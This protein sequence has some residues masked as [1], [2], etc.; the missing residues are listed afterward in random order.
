MCIYTSLYL[1]IRVILYT[2]AT[3][4]KRHARNTETED[5][6][7]RRPVPCGPGLGVRACKM[8]DIRYYIDNKLAMRAAYVPLA[9]PVFCLVFL[10][11][12]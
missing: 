12:E 9:L 5:T 7:R 8:H 11:L 10:D 6:A 2:I 1:H 4:Y 3:I